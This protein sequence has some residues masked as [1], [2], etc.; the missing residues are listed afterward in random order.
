M[1]R[2][3]GRKIGAAIQMPKNATLK[4][5]KNGEVDPASETAGAGL[6]VGSA[7]APTS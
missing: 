5:Q 2:L 6:L 7:A 1:W 4:F 3:R